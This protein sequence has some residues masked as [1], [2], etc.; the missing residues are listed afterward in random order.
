MLD[1]DNMVKAWR[2]SWFK[3]TVDPDYVGFWKSYLDQL[4]VNKG[5]LFLIQCNYDINQLTISA[6]FYQDLLDWWS[7]LREVKDPKNIHKYTLWNNKEVRI[8]GK[9]VFY[10]HF[11]IIISYTQLSCFMR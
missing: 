8:D 3:R 9:R 10:K 4:L 2:L 11:L 1:Y 6:F 5:G 7:K